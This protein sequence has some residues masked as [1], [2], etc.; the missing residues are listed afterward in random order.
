MAPDMA[1]DMDETEH[2]EP[3]ASTSRK[4]PTFHHLCADMATSKLKWG[5]AQRAFHHV[6]I[7]LPPLAF[8]KL[9]WVVFRQRGISHL[10]GVNP[11][12]S[13]QYPPV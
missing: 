4:P 8:K 6:L 11:A 5:E 10:P 9:Q 2:Q 7:T 12:D 13:Q 3:A 1:P